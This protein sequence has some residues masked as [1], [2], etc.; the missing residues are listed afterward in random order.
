M[1]ST[2]IFLLGGLIGLCLYLIW[3]EK[4]KRETCSKCGI[5][6]PRRKRKVFCRDCFH[7]E[8]WDRFEKEDETVR[9]T[10]HEMLDRLG[11]KKRKG[12]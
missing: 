12:G 2:M 4:F 6:L 11:D 5:F 8:V 3:K 9:R 7:A 10:L 1:E